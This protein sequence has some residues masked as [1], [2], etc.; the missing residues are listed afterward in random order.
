VT[1][2]LQG[3][4]QDIRHFAAEYFPGDF[5]VAIGG[6]RYGGGDAGLGEGT[7]KCPT[8][9]DVPLVYFGEAAEF[10]ELVFGCLG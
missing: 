7:A 8:T 6:D 2:L 5:D 10:E 1:A 4:D 3:E 9:E